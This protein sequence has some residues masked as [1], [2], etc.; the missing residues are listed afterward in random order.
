MGEGAGNLYEAASALCQGINTLSQ[1]T[2]ADG[3]GCTAGEDAE[4][5]VNQIQAHA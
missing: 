2:H 4:R 5:R 3:V 1:G